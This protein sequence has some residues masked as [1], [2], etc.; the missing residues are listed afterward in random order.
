ME[1][2]V[3]LPLSSWNYKADTAT[4]HVGPMAQDFYAAFNVGPDDKHIATVDADGLVTLRTGDVFRLDL[5]QSDQPQQGGR[6]GGGDEPGTHG[7]P[8]FRWPPGGGPAPS[9]HGGAG[10][11]ERP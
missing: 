6:C 3:A 5:P 1:K 8:P 2:V 7:E 10:A 11:A 9:S 4:R